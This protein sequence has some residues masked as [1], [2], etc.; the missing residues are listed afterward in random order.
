MTD[1]SSAIEEAAGTEGAGVVTTQSEPPVE[2]AIEEAAPPA[3][4]PVA[5]PRKRR[6]GLIVAI[7]AIVI[8]VGA[9]AVFALYDANQ[10]AEARQQSIKT[11]SI[12]ADESLDKMW[13]QMAARDKSWTLVDEGSRGFMVGQ[14][15][16][17]AT[18]DIKKWKLVTA[19]VRD[20]MDAVEDESVSS[21]YI[22]ICD[23]VD[24]VLTDRGEQL[25][26]VADTAGLTDQL[27]DSDN[28]YL[29]GW[30]KMQDAIGSC[31]AKKWT[32]A[33]NQA[34][35]AQT[36]YQGAANTCA[37]V[38]K[39]LKDESLKRH[40]AWL[41]QHVEWAKMA[42]ELAAIG[43]RGGV[44]SYNKQITRL[45]AKE[46]EIAGMDGADYSPGF[47][48]EPAADAGGTFVSG[49]GKARDLQTEARA[50]VTEALTE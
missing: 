24:S 11:A 12:A 5:T 23:E 49:T 28:D 19:E 50:A 10:K 26:L 22:A 46:A 6:T 45:D 8:L 20:S 7:V 2:P 25:A 36:L 3:A 13:E 48:W 40:I 30:D 38:N 35:E 37:T 18:D 47:G 1:E 43:K 39:T 14:L 33:Q 34:K 32:Q 4:E 42:Q 17:F 29:D 15:S 16:G 44:N 41:S 27:A 21:A 31:N 9:G